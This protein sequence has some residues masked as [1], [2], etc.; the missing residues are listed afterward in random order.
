M[1]ET[2]HRLRRIHNFNGFHLLTYCFRFWFTL[3]ILLP[4]MRDVSDEFFIFQQDSA[5]AHWTRDTVRLLEVAM[6][7]FIP[8][9][10]WPPNSPDLN[11]IDYKIWSVVSSSE[12]ISHGCTTLT[13]SSS[14]S[15]TLCT[16]GDLNLQD[17]KM[18]K[19]RTR[20]NL[21]TGYDE[22]R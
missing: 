8:P 20:L 15:C 16:A 18:T 21:Y 13:N 5:S 11:P 19:Y 12:C 10:L 1:I 7:A 17:W 22:K 2:K 3:N 6:P 14:V 4:M 9:D